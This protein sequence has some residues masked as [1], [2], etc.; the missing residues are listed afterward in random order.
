MYANIDRKFTSEP[1]FKK[2]IGEFQSVILVDGSSDCGHGNRP[3]SE[4]MLKFKV[5]GTQG[6]I[7]A[8]AIVKES[9]P[10]YKLVSISP[11]TYTSQNTTKGIKN[12]PVIRLI[13]KC[14]A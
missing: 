6:C 4:N 2:N 10:I 13:D 3:C 14:A 9:F 5:F 8:N 12:A 1:I 11:S 7:Y